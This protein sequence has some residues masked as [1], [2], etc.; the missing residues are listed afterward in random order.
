MDDYDSQDYDG[1]NDSFYTYDADNDSDG[2]GFYNPVRDEEN[3]SIRPDFLNRTENGAVGNQASKNRDR[4]NLAKKDLKSSE[5]VAAKNGSNGEKKKDGNGSAVS[6]ARALEKGAAAANPT[7]RI[8][9]SVKGKKNEKQKGGIKKKAATIAAILTLFGG[10]IGIASIGQAFQPFAYI[11]NVMQNFDIGSY[12]STARMRT[13]MKA[14]M[15]AAKGVK[16]SPQ[17]KQ[18]LAR[19]GVET[20]VDADGKVTKYQYDAGDNNVKAI[21]NEAELD[22]ALKNDNVLKSKTAK[23]ANDVNNDSFFG[24]VKSFAMERINALR[25]RWE[26]YNDT[27]DANGSKKQFNE[28]ASGEANRKKTAMQSHAD[29]EE[30]DDDGEVKAKTDDATDTDATGKKTINDLIEVDDSDAGDVKIKSTKLDLGKISKVTKLASFVDCTYVLVSQAVAA[31]VIG[32][33]IMDMINAG[34]GV[35]EATQKCQVG[36]GGDCA[37]MKGYMDEANS[38]DFWQATTIRSIFGGGS[39]GIT[40][41]IANLENIFNN[42]GILSTLVRSGVSVD[43][44]RKCLYG[45]MIAAGVDLVGDLADVIKTIATGGAYAVVMI[46]KKVALGAVTSLAVSAAVGQGVKTMISLA[47]KAMNFDVI[48]DMGSK[49]MGEYSTGGM[50]RMLAAAAQSTGSAMGTSQ[51]VSEFNEYKNTVIA[52]RAKYDKD[53]LSPFD[54][55]SQNTFLGSLMHSMAKFSV[56]TSSANTPLVRSISSVGSLLGSSVAS[57]MPQA[58]AVE[59]NNVADAPGDCWLVNSIEA[60]GDANLCYEY[61][62]SDTDTFDITYEEAKEYLCNSG[63]D[64][65]D[66]SLENCESGTPKIKSDSAVAKYVEYWTLRD[67]HPGLAD[68][69]ITADSHKA[70]TGNGTVDG[71]ISSVPVIGSIVDFANASFEGDAQDE[72][73]AS[74]YVAGSEHWGVEEQNIQTFL[75]YDTIYEQLGLLEKSTLAAY[76]DDYYEKNPLDTSYEG[77]LARFSGLPKEMVVDTLAYMDYLEFVEEYNPGEYYAFSDNKIEKGIVLKDDGDEGFEYLPTTEIAYFD[78]RNKNYAV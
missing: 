12:S 73:F 51:K 44:W 42:K 74:H 38:G 9:N 13:T 54:I 26:G 72:I 64:G 70:S 63:S 34:S 77:T 69:S 24:K 19:A 68:S 37:A 76:L 28:I 17:F 67:T 56:L 3:Y 11:N 39:S 35:A 36:E 18:A 29:Y 5:N 27:D 10:G 41:G 78:L 75:E 15:K 30:A 33:Q 8:I 23:A 60:V 6:G 4:N 50:K 57:M 46:I 20:E 31:V 14:V 45:K 53:N 52:D 25:N 1:D 40:A 43:S 7:A 65:H 47:A 49:L 61:T 71:I 58:M 55:T 59:Y 22:A 48:L 62:L 21:T 32:Q 66:E 2:G 16:V